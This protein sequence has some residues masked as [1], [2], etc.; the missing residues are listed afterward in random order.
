VQNIID[1]INKDAKEKWLDYFTGASVVIPFMIGSPLI[2]NIW[3]RKIFYATSRN[4][5]FVTV[6]G[7]ILLGDGTEN[8]IEKKLQERMDKLN[9]FL[10]AGINSAKAEL[11]DENLKT[12]TFPNAIE[13]EVILTTP[14]SNTLVELFTKSDEYIRMI[15]ALW[16]H[17]KIS[18][19]EKNTIEREIR[20]SILGLWT[21]SRTL[22]I[23]LRNRIA[24]KKAAG[25]ISQSVAEK[26][27]TDE[28]QSDQLKV[29]SLNTETNASRVRKIPE[30]TADTVVSQNQIPEH[31]VAAVA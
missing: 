4:L 10:S 28:T 14:M 20:K 27:L 11:A 13:G 2:K 12:A 1:N 22:T 9:A 29:I 21:S 25:K 8:E 24:A 19:Q 31:A 17:K 15:A 16:I 3:N 5:H 30:V 18:G 7:P 26:A 23:G 6:F